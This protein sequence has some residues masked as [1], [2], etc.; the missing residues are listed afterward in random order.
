[1]GSTASDK[2]QK[3]TSFLYQENRRFFALLSGGLEEWGAAELA[4]L[5]AQDIHAGFRGFY[6][7][8]DSRML[9]Q[10]LYG[11]RLFSRVLAPLTRFD[12]HSTKY[13]HRR[14]HAFPWESLMSLDDTFAIQAVTS[15]SAIRHSRYAALTMKDAIADRFREQTG[16]R[17]SVETRHPDVA[18]HLYI[19]RNQA[20]VSLD[21]SGGSLHRRGYRVASVEAPMQET[22][23]AGMVRAC[24]WQGDRPLYD[25]FCGSGTLLCEAWMHGC[26]IPAGYLRTAFGLHRLPDFDDALWRDVK[27]AM[28]A[29]IELLPSSL[30]TG[31]DRDPQAIGAAR[32]NLNLLPGGDRVALQVA[33]FSDFRGCSNAMLIMNPPYGLRLGHS[34]DAAA[35]LKQLG[36]LLKQRCAGSEA[37]LYYGDDTLVKKLGLK[38]AWKK[39][40]RNGGLDGRCC[41]YTLF[42]GSRDA[43]AK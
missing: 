40:V 9:Y 30:V 13:L 38:P 27:G 37:V 6:F 39:S 5:G 11:T 33:D 12:C 10:V 29:R 17:P 42:A 35:L 31:S 43:Q 2:E 14:L 21:L 26:R 4:E 41:A 36:D 23:A 32:T 16:R 8:A 1:M 25:L 7:K 20:T 28:D 34:R 19:E 15:H 3:D 18:L 22:L 24:G